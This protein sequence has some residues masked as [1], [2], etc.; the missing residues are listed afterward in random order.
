MP[1]W[2]GPVLQILGF[3]LGLAAF[4][5]SFR[6]FKRSGPLTDLQTRLATLELTAKKRAA[7]S[8]SQADVRV[9]ISQPGQHSYRLV[10]ENRGAGTASN[11]NIA[12][13]HPDHEQMFPHGIRADNLPIAELGSNDSVT[14]LIALASGRYP[15]FD[16][17]VTWTDP[18]GT[19]R[20]KV[21]KL[22]LS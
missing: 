13:Q 14:M 7:V 5:V 8:L 22:R 19:E 4:V 18:D 6:A 9:S 17:T 2:L 20:R 3:I 11:V 12:F 16:C 15:P 1:A 10:F 21:G